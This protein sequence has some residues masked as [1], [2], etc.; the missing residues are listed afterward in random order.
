MKEFKFHYICENIHDI[1]YKIYEPF[2]PARYLSFN[3]WQK[4]D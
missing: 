4:K 2:K 3:N 1:T